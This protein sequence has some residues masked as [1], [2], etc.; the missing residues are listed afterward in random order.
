MCAI[1]V[2]CIFFLNFSVLSCFVFNFCVRSSDDYVSARCDDSMGWL[3][4]E[5]VKASEIQTEK[6]GGSKGQKAEGKV[7]NRILGS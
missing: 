6:L 5:L 7:F 2:F 3:E 1:H 4:A